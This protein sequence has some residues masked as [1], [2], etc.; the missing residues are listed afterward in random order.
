MNDVKT[1]T[2][3]IPINS[4]VYMN[5]VKLRSS[6][7]INPHM[8]S[9]GIKRIKITRYISEKYKTFKYFKPRSC[10]TFGVKIFKLHP[11]LSSVFYAESHVLLYQDCTLI[12]T[13]YDPLQSNGLNVHHMVS[14]FD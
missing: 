8:V 3:L 1:I 11:F 2:F 14:I 7:L 12:Q 9:S 5:M 10:Q 4:T 13:L 6:I